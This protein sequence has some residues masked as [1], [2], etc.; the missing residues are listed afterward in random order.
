MEERLL[1]FARRI[2]PETAAYGPEEEARFRETVAAGLKERSAKMLSQLSLFLTVLEWSPVL[3][4]GAPY[5]KLGAQEQDAVLR[6]YQDAPI[7][8]LRQG[9]WGVK[10]LCFMGH[11]G[12]PELGAS[13]NYRPSRG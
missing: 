9:L 7:T 1:G 8:K 5:S 4:Y 6:Y 13:I 11:Y 12:R 10:L 3:R 2:V